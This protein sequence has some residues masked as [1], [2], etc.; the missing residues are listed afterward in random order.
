MLKRMVLVAGTILVAA[1]AA[2]ADLII[3]DDFENPA[4]P[5]TLVSYEE[6][7]GYTPPSGEGT[8]L[9]LPPGS[10]IGGARA[11]ALTYIGD[12]SAG[13]TAR[14]R[15]VGSAGDQFLSFSNEGIIQSEFELTYGGDPSLGDPLQPLD[16]DFTEQ[17]GIKILI[18]SADHPS[19]M[20]VEV[21]SD[22]G[23]TVGYGAVAYDIP[24]GGPQE[25]EI[26]GDDFPPGI[27]GSDIDKIQFTFGLA[28]GWRPIEQERR[29]AA[30][31]DLQIDLIQ[32]LPIPEPATLSLLALGGLGLL[33]RR[34]RKS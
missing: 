15:I 9:S 10:T 8:N 3:I 11:F 30:S 1:L 32:S 18:R 2:Q 6:G 17:A 23:G 12:A 27:D 31:L 7:V 16:A 33:A 21:W 26:H 20:L 13:E 19:T 22:I 24:A 29:Y 4:S 28:H 14:A 25:I 34:R 5:L